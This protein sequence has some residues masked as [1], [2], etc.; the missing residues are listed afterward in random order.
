[1]IAVSRVEYHHPIQVSMARGAIAVVAHAI[2]STH[3]PFITSKPV[4]FLFPTADINRHV[5]HVLARVLKARGPFCRV[6]TRTDSGH[7]R[8]GA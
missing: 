7:D 4:A 2:V 1:M 3:I 8:G 5:S 6:P